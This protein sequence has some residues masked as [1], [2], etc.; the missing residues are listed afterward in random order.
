M[1]VKKV[2]LTYEQVKA[3]YEELLTAEYSDGKVG[4]SNEDLVI[5][6]N[7]TKKYFGREMWQK[8]GFAKELNGLLSKMAPDSKG[9]CSVAYSLGTYT[10]FCD[11]TSFS[12]TFYI[13]NKYIIDYL[14]ERKVE[15]NAKLLM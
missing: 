4:F 3:L 14:I 7:T 11:L 8:P 9:N 1:S 13:S 10:G 6:H 5:A 2:S 15:I 12:V